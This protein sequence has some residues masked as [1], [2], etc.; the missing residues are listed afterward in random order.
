MVEFIL[1][2]II[3]VLVFCSCYFSSSESALFSLSETKVR[4]YQHSKDPHKKLIAALLRKPQELLVTIFVLNTVV[5]I[6]IQNAISGFI[7][8]NGSWIGKIF[9]PFLILLF[10]G[11]IFPKQ[12]GL[13]KNI[14]ISKLTAKPLTVLHQ[15][16]LPLFKLIVGIANSI[17]KLLFFFLKKGEDIGSEEIQ[18]VLKKSEEL[19]VLHPDE[20]FLASGFLELRDAQVKEIMRPKEEIIAYEI[21]EPM[22]KLIHLFVDQECTRIPIYR[23]NLDQVLGIISANQFFAHKNKIFN[24]Q[25]LLEHASKPFFCPETTQAKVLLKQF[26]LKDEVFSLCVDE[27]GIITGLI[28]KE[29]LIEVVIGS[30]KDL[31]DQAVY[32]TKVNDNT[33]IAK[34][35]TDIEEIEKIFGI[36]LENPEE[37]SSIGGWLTQAHGDIPATGWTYEYKNLFFRILSADPN[38][39]TKVFIQRRGENAQ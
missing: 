7:G 11:E 5:N 18:H 27:Y 15:F 9:I 35:Q 36:E 14:A 17:S 34:G 22:S 2:G 3:L 1:F 6:L 31:R 21:N 32:Y 8:E 16:F 13:E 26:D 25:N 19:G 4:A 24:A 29:D 23:G 20:A 30:V 28:T 10:F 37:L 12:V 39:V 33:V 38:K